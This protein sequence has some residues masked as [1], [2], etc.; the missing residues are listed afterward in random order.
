MSAGSLV[1]RYMAGQAALTTRSNVHAVECMIV[2]S[3]RLRLEWRWRFQ[4]RRALGIYLSPTTNMRSIV[5]AQS[6]RD[7]ATGYRVFT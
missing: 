3:S 5:W 1:R 4:L 7:R 2:G 6:E